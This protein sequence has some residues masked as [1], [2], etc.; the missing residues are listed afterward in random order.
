[1]DRE[2][3]IGVLGGMG[4]YAGLDL[5][6]KIFGETRAQTDQ[7]HLPVAMLSF[8]HEI[9]DRT[10]YVLGHVS[11][12]PGHAI[13]RIAIKL[14]TLGAT[15]AGM[16]CNSAHMPPI[17]DV[18]S[19]TLH[20][21]H[22][23]IR[24]LH[25]IDETIRFVQEALPHVRRVG[26][27]STLGTFRLGV[28][29]QAIA[30]AGLEPVMPTETVQE[31]LVNRAIYHPEFGIKAQS[32]PVTERARTMVQGAMDHLWDQGAEA[33]I[34]GCTELP[35]AV[36]DATQPEIVDPARALARAL[37][38]ETYPHKLRPL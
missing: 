18:V 38:R 17:F 7:D 12:S 32:A 10:A 8:G 3:V 22:H 2:P 29:K 11:E 23:H 24:I 37:I 16:P 1:M 28:Y 9:A 6:E 15:V 14:E 35:L 30:D 19:S 27:L 34:L 33:V 26:P 21:G 13:A 36:P 31:N 5:V 25:L 20:A 4:P